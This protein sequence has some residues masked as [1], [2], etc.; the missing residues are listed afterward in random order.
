MITLDRDN[1]LKQI[2][3]SEEVSKKLDIY[4]ETLEKWQG[5]MNLVS[6]TT[7]PIVWT[8]HILDSAQLYKLIKNEDKIIVDFGS[9]SGF[10]GLVLAILDDK[11]R[12]YHLIESDG[13]KCNFL[14]EI[15]KLCNLNVIVH[16]ERIEKIKNLKPNVITARALTSLVELVKYANMYTSEKTRYIFMKGKKAPEEI[17]E[18]QKQFKIEF[19]KINSITS[20]EGQILIINKVTKK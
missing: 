9:G 18:C 15:V 20:P 5:F 14:N 7:L 8:R 19:E 11:N 2:N 16:N 6:D 10:P 3:A 13:K 17:K 4:V 1:T 12:E